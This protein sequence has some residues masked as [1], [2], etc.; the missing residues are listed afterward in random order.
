[1]YEL[2]GAT[3]PTIATTLGVTVV[4]IRWHLSRGRREMADR[5]RGGR[6][7]ES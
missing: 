1:M 4:T 5:I 3:I 2:E 6:G 7:G